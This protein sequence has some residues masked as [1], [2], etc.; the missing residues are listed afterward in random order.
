MPEA[1]TDIYPNPMIRNYVC[2]TIGFDN[3]SMRTRY[4]NS[5]LVSR[6]AHWKHAKLVSDIYS[7]AHKDIIGKIIA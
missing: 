1:T 6:Y 4:Q 7:D 5:K 3:V 2:S